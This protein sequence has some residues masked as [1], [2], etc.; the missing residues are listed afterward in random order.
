[1]QAQVLRTYG[2]DAQFELDDV[3]I[4]TMKP[5]HLL[6]QVKATSLNPVDSKIRRLGPPIA[7]DFPAILHGDVAGV[8]KEV[9]EGI[10]G[11]RPGDAVYGCAG[12]VKGEGGALAEYML[13]DAQLVAHKP[14]TLDFAESAALPLISITAWEGLIDRARVQPQ[15][16]VLVHGAAGGVGHLA[17]QLAAIKGATVYAT[18]STKDKGQIGKRL[19]A[20]DI[21]YYRDESPDA[22]VKRL[23]NGEG[24]DIVFDTVGG[25]NIDQAFKAA[26]NNG[27][28]ITIVSQSTHDLSLMHQR[29]LSFHVVFMLLPM[30]TGKGRAH[31]GEILR[32]IATWVDEGKVTPLLDST[33]FTFSD[34]NR[35]HEYFEAGSHIGKIVIEHSS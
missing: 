13:V 22:Y 6:V 17:I 21:I 31:Q 34:I 12:G 32:Q 5:G 16:N 8:V 14:Q 33:R 4:P 1:M 26:A 29:G 10:T 25:T 27:Q 9:G 7:P 23:T 28:V 30:L 18:A 19:G 20:K 15:Q 3:P 35:A 11:F 24:F 2:V